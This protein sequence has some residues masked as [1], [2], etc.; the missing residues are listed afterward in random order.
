MGA[1][2]KLASFNIGGLD[3]PCSVAAAVP[4][5]L[6]AVAPLMKAAEGYPVG[7][8]ERQKRVK[9]ARK[10]LDRV[11]AILGEDLPNYIENEG[12]FSVIWGVTKNIIAPILLVVLVL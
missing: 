3:Y 7:S 11:Y 9:Q 5:M 12:V 8:P 2:D 4:Q 6:S 1:G 10:I